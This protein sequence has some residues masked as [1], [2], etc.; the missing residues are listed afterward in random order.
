MRM[1]MIDE[2]MINKL[3]MRIKMMMWINELMMT[4]MINESFLLE[5]SRFYKGH[6]LEGGEEGE[7][8]RWRACWR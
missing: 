7:G 1:R 8:R 5:I 2:L 4:M 6:L 3:T